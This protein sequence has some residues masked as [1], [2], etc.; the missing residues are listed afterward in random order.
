M[1]GSY[2]WRKHPFILRT[3]I[4]DGKN[5]NSK[6]FFNQVKLYTV[7]RNGNFSALTLFDD[8]MLRNTLLHTPGLLRL[9]GSQ[10][11]SKR[12]MKVIKAKAKAR[13]L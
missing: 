3:S 5:K 2:P 12:P 8:I 10:K 11:N 13:L 1:N 6:W 7:I 4:S 9:Q